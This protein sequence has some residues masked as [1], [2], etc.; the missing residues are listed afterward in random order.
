MAIGLC[1]TLTV[2]GGRGGAAATMVTV[3]ALA[4]DWYVF[5]AGRAGPFTSTCAALRSDCT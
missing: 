3:D 5:L 4:L 1:L 2:G